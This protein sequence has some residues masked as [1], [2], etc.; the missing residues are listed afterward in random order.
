MAAVLAGAALGVCALV[1]PAQ[2]APPDDADA[3]VV[4]ERDVYVIVGSTLRS[5]DATTDPTAPLFNVAGVALGFTWGD[6]SQGTATSVVRQTGGASPRSDVRLELTG[7]VP[8]GVNSVFWGTL[9]PD[10]ENPLC[11]GVE[12]TLALTSTDRRQAPDAS[13]FVA[14]A[15]GSARFGG[16]VDGGLL[17][18][19]QAFFS[20]VY[21]S[22]GETYGA[23]PN[24]GE[25]LTQGE[26]CRSSFGEDAMRQLI[27]LQTS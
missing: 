11:P 18:A 23:L 9:G 4:Y 19:T 2:A 21:H 3:V 24:R 25:W 20:I 5:P 27:I 7:L 15:D 16:R 1:T 13:S 26:S 14:D 22:D 10:S 17:D 8:G 12:R 6:W